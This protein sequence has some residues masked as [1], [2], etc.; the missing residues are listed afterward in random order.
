MALQQA[1]SSLLLD[2]AA[3]LRRR[4]VRGGRDDSVSPAAAEGLSNFLEGIARSEPALH[5]ADLNE[6]I[7]LAHRLI[8]DDHPEHSRLWPA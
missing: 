1:Q 6:A 4:Y 5:Q 2:A 8:D 7:A 3:V